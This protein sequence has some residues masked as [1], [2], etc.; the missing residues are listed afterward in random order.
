MGK[1]GNVNVETKLLVCFK[2]IILD[3]SVMMYGVPI[4]VTGNGTHV[5][6]LVNP[7]GISRASDVG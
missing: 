5:L 7:R 4:V 2:M 1:I 3:G 6:G